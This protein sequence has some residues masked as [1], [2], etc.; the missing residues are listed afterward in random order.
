MV[1]HRH[2]P[3]GRRLLDVARVLRERDL[4]AGSLVDHMGEQGLGLLLLVLTLP[5]IIPVPG[6]FGMVFGALL[7]LVALQ[8]MFG[9]SRLWLPER[10]R[11]R[12]VP[13]QFLRAVIRRA[14]PLVS[15]PERA[16]H[17]DRLSWLTGRRARMSF[18]A[19]LLV[20]AVTIVL[21]IPFGNVLPAIALLVAAIGFIAH[22]GL[23]VLI[24]MVIVALALLWTLA[25][26]FFGAELFRVAADAATTLLASWPF[27]F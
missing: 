16:L 26:F 14:L 12:A 10:L 13:R 23:A 19:P 1:R 11:S 8:I 25:L 20:M 15:V 21:P 17:E 22:D 24:S 7:S 5:T 27:G 9:A 2:G 3:V 6:P 4:T 18:A